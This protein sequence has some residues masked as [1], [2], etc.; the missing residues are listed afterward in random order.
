MT[1]KTP[2]KQRTEKSL[3]RNRSTYFLINAAIVCV[4]LVMCG[5][6]VFSPADVQCVYATKGL[7]CPTCG[8]TRAFRTVLSLD[9]N[10]I[11]LQQGVFKIAFFFLV[12][13]FFRFVIFILTLRNEWPNSFTVMDVAFSVVIFVWAFWHLLPF[14]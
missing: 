4:L 3:L 7:I 14:G 9:F 5:W 6:I 2:P 8:L 1:T 12:Q 10:H 11:H 13:L